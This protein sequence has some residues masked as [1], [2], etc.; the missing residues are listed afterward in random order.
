LISLCT[1]KLNEGP[2]RIAPG[3][4]FFALAEGFAVPARPL[5]FGT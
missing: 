1:I 3:F 2:G 4:R 5:Y